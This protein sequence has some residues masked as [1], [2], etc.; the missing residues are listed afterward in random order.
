M[1]VIENA[2]DKLRAM[3]AR[4]RASAQTRDDILT[5]ADE[6]AKAEAAAAQE[7][8]RAEADVRISQLERV[9]GKLRAQGDGLT[10]VAEEARAK[11][12]D[13]FAAVQ[14][15]VDEAVAIYN[16][17]SLPDRQRVGL[18]NDVTLWAGIF[19]HGG[20]VDLL[21]VGANLSRKVSR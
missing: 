18:P 14:K 19:T 20:E 3:G 21:V 8:A 6:D 17:L 9:Y 4:A 5:A 16:Q 2:R 10:A 1:N 12:S 13:G 7:L 15:T 11:I